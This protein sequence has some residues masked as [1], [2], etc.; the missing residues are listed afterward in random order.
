[1]KP[2]FA[3]VDCNNF[4]VSCERVF[5]P[6]LAGKPVIV[7]SNND[8]CAV[9]RSEEA[10]AIGIKMGAPA[11]KIRSLLDAHSVH[12]FSS[13][14]ALYG[15]MS[16]RVMQTLTD[17]APSIEIYSIDEAFLDVSGMRHEN[18]TA[19]GQHIRKTVKQ[20]TGIPVSV[21]IARTKTLA[22]IANRIAKKSIRENGVLDLT[23]SPF[24]EEAL[25]RID[26]E[27]VWG[28]G[29]KYA[30]RLKKY[31]IHTALSLAKLDDRWIQKLM[32]VNGARIVKE[33]QGISCYG[34]DDSPPPK[35]GIGVSRTFYAEIDKFD[36]LKTAVSGYVCRAAEKLRAQKSAAN[37][38]MIFAATNRFKAH[39]DFHIATAA[40]PVPTSDTTEMLRYADQCLRQVYKE[41]IRYKKAGVFLSALVS[42]ERVQAGLFDKTDRPRSKCLM[43]TLDRINEKMGAGT[44]RYAA[45]GL[46]SNETWR[47]IS[48]QR[49]PAYT[50]DWD[51]IPMVA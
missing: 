37:V 48:R 6:K 18:L 35:K 46:A 19:Y 40:L 3:L 12:A 30:H 47:T 43:E 17:M 15:D 27:D 32:G 13:N 2:I 39:Y 7:L 42:A 24:L 26:L 9:A 51:Q 49:S 20:W 31:G 45:A 44:V 11:F 5:N 28:I 33:L 34:L 1:M 38:M 14:Y 16:R 4:Y 23:D 41:D 10:K 8:G 25:K 29:R 22:K 50:T 21:G 36:D